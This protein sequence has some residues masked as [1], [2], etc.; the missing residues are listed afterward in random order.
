MNINFSFQ[1]DK[2]FI[3]NI[4]FI[5]ISSILNL[6]PDTKTLFLELECIREKS[7]DI[8]YFLYSVKKVNMNVI[9]VLKILKYLFSLSVGEAKMLYE[10]HF[11]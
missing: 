2:L 5:C 11:P 7:V 8:E 10:N 4:D 9:D 1:E 3:N 6:L